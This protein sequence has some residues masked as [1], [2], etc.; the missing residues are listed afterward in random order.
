[1]FFS[2]CCCSEVV[3]AAPRPVPFCSAPLQSPVR[4]GRCDTDYK[5]TRETGASTACSG[6][7]PKPCSTRG[8]GHEH[9]QAPRPS[10]CSCGQSWWESW[11]PAAVQE[12]A[13]SFVLQ[14]G[15][16][17]SQELWAWVLAQCF[18]APGR[19]L[20]G[21]DDVKYSVKPEQDLYKQGSGKIIYF[22][23]W[24]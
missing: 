12:E 21:L 15:A 22:S 17:D 19:V 14:R 13:S 16:A 20:I 6:P 3:E 2:S 11:A 5:L 1:M 9:A 23:P 24:K 10:T 7:N 8:A 18:I 4:K